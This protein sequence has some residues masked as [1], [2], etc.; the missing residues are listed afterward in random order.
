MHLRFWHWLTLVLLSVSVLPAQATRY[1]ITTTADIE[2]GS[3]CSI[4]DAVEAINTQEPV[5]AC[6]A[7]EG[8]DRINLDEGETYELTEMLEIGNPDESINPDVRIVI[9]DFDD[10]LDQDNAVLKIKDGSTDRA[11]RIKSN[12]ALELSKITVTNGHASG[13]GEEENGG[14][15]YVESSAALTITDEARLENGTADGL[16]GLVYSDSGTI[17]IRDESRLINGAATGGGAIYLAGD[18]NFASLEIDTSAVE[19]NDADPG[20]GGGLA[21]A[22][23]FNGFISLNRAYIGGNSA[24]NDGGGLYLEDDDSGD[25]EFQ[26]LIVNTTFAGNSSTSGAG[27]FSWNEGDADDQ[28]LIMNNVTVAKNDS[29]GNG[30]VYI[31]SGNDSDRIINSVLVGEQSGPPDCGGGAFSSSMIMEFNVVGNGCDTGSSS[32]TAAGDPS[33]QVLRNKTE[34]C[35]DTGCELADLEPFPSYLPAT[36]DSIE[37]ALNAGNPNDQASN[38]CSTQD[39]RGVSRL[40]DNCDAGAIEFETAVGETDEFEIVWGK[41]EI[42]DVAGND[43][44]DS[45][46]DCD[47]IDPGEE[48]LGYQ[49]GDPEIDKCVQVIVPP[50]RPSASV[51]FHRIG[52]VPSAQLSEE[53]ENKNYPDGYPVARYRPGE[54]YHGLD[55]FSYRINKDAFLATRQNRNVEAE[56][57]IVSQPAGGLQEDDS[58]EQIGSFPSMLIGMISLCG[59]WR[60]RRWLAAMGVCLLAPGLQAAEIQ[61]DSLEDN[62]IE[63]DGV[64]TLREAIRSSLDDQENLESACE[65]GADGR[66]TI[67]LPRGCITLDGRSLQI[68]DPVTIRGE[69]PHGIDRD[70]DVDGSGRLENSVCSP[71]AESNG[72]WTEGTIVHGD[73][74]S[75][76]FENNS[77]LRLED[78]SLIH[79]S[80]SSGPHGGAIRADANLDIARVEFFGNESTEL[81]G[82]IYI[83]GVPT[84][85]EEQEVTISRSYFLD[86]SAGTDGGALAM[87]GA[88]HELEIIDSTFWKN[89]AGENGGAA[90]MAMSRGSMWVVNSTFVDNT[91]SDTGG[92]DFRE[93]VGS[94]D[95][96]NSFSPNVNIVNNTIVDNGD[97]GIDFG[98]RQEANN[99]DSLRTIRFNNNVLVGNGFDECSSHSSDPQPLNQLLFNLLSDPAPATCSTDFSGTPDS[100]DE[101]ENDPFTDSVG[102]LFETDGNNELLLQPNV[103]NDREDFVPPNL[104]VQDEGTCGSAGN[105]CFVENSAS[106]REL[107]DGATEDVRQCRSA[108]VRGFTRESGKRCDR[109][110]YEIQETTAVDD[111]AENQ[112]DDGGMVFIDVLDNDST[113][114]ASDYEIDQGS[115]SVIPG[116]TESVNDEGGSPEITKVYKEFP[117]VQCG[118]QAALDEA[119]ANDPDAEPGEY[120]C[121][122]K[123]DPSDNGSNQLGCTDSDDDLPIELTEDEGDPAFRYQFEAVDENDNPSPD[124][125]SNEADV[126][127]TIN[128]VPP[129]IDSETV[130]N[131]PGEKVVIDLNVEDKFGPEGKGERVDYSSLE[132]A[133]DPQFADVDDN[134]DIVGTGVKLNKPR[135]GQITYVPRDKTKTFTDRFQVRVSDHCGEES[136]GGQ[137]VIR[138]PQE[139]T[140]GGEL[141]GGGSLGLGSLIV[142]VGLGGLRRRFRV[143]VQPRL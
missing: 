81:G 136:D 133:N 109:G 50:G 22:P 85:S 110:A 29:G 16:G 70:Q 112:A 10:D 9:E 73:E 102:N 74:A 141:L 116:S 139:D 34:N 131:T 83:A 142:L 5:G 63:G 43:L 40:E 97:H 96:Q 15:V 64:C 143:G 120:D 11:F 87:A 101:R 66:D 80:T 125:P 108:D 26:A 56:T 91:A 51:S 68:D 113:D 118:N 127:L 24:S 72:D 100:Q 61:V 75:R 84:P 59:L 114:P 67:I 38:A 14:L 95:P 140:S 82:G 44:G 78:M 123:Y 129:R 28:T 132:L 33:I 128:N 103:G 65:D 138:Y 99:G 58:I 92:L 45:T 48:L 124:S 94:E 1:E 76:I 54:R 18:E 122:V 135:E 62:E 32:N 20:N 126:Y 137:I 19:G 49:F 31:A 107:A 77:A 55:R 53:L 117:S 86:N 130:W 39:Q 23:E 88:R 57:N 37:T 93:V 8:N 13:S 47:R 12:A 46:L 52:D 98:A 71:A 2:D 90:D 27:A 105:T 106:D 104:R 25:S 134:G 119:I 121:V 111:S 69:G 60:R 6:E 3:E 7:G 89:S 21:F 41:T 42:V 17:S 79:G 36:D 4:R 30:S 35:T 115:I